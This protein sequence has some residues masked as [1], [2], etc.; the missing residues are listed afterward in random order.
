MDWTTGQMTGFA[1]AEP[2]EIELK[3][4][5]SG[6]LFDL[7]RNRDVPVSN[8]TARVIL[9]PGEGT[10]LLLGDAAGAAAIRERVEK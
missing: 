8:G 3:L 6:P 7:K 4:E 10:L 2:Q 9:E 1:A 5:Q